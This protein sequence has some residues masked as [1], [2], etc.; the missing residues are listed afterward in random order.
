MTRTPHFL[1]HNFPLYSSGLFTSGHRSPTASHHLH[2]P[3][4]S[5]VLTLG[6]AMVQ[7]SRGSRQEQQRQGSAG[8]GRPT[9]SPLPPARLPPPRPTSQSRSRPS[10]AAP[11]VLPS[12]GSEVLSALFRDRPRPG[13]DAKGHAPAAPVLTAGWCRGHLL[14]FPGDCVL[15][16]GIHQDSPTVVEIETVY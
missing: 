7:E 6:A 5:S 8:S 3:C 2:G 13:P 16:Q 4:V 15:Q 9:A 14:S 12:P 1:R 10:L 11:G